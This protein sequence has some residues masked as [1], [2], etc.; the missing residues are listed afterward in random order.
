MS[1]KISIVLP[2]FNGETH[3]AK[4]IHSILAQTLR[5]WE[6]IIVNDA[7]SDRTG[8]IA[9]EF[10]S[11][12]SRITVLHHAE[13]RKLPA[14]LNTGFHNARGCYWTWTS[15]DNTYE[16]EAL[17]RMSDYLDSHENAVMVCAD[18]LH[19]QEDG[20]RTV[21]FS[22]KTEAADLI[23]GGACGPCFLYRAETARQIGDY[24][25]S[26]FLVEDWDYWLRMG[27]LGKIDAIHEVLYRY[28]FHAN[29]L[30]ARF[31]TEIR[32]RACLLKAEYMPQYLKQY[33]EIGSNV[34]CMQ[35]YYP[36]VLFLNQEKTQFNRI[37]SSLPVR[38]QLYFCHWRFRETGD[39]SYLRK[40]MSLGA[41]GFL[42]ACALFVLGPLPQETEAP[43]ISD[44][45]DDS[46][47]FR[48]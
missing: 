46:S 26:K 36:V 28:L 43:R 1:P 10:A 23:C 8:T 32:R 22:V 31:Q 25:S 4:A 29:S 13:N 48:K 15:D 21:R 17:Q 45:N 9:E 7:S 20:E 44:E 2:T 27:L 47:T 38:M 30:T 12:D 35:N 14:A 11:E 41:H 18:C 3:I 39:R 5:D 34:S 33:P 40:L 37:M 24:D 6:L 42:R 16:P 19:I